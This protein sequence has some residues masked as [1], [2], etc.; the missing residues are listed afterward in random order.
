MR[1]PS[2]DQEGMASLEEGM[3]TH[4][5]ILAWRI[6]ETEEPGGLQSMGS[7]S[8]T[9]LHDQLTLSRVCGEPLA[10]SIF[11][12]MLQ[13]PSPCVTRDSLSGKGAPFAFSPLR[14]SAPFSPEET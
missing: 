3:A 8:R 10:F 12:L 6:P 4:P 2:L 9:W 14:L 5:N 11:Y 7:Q 13:R 1:V